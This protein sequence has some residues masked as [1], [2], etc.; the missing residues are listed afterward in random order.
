MLR[1]IAGY[2]VL[3]RS[4]HFVSLF[5]EKGEC[6]KACVLHVGACVCRCKSECLLLCVMH[7]AQHR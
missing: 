3:C 4:C 6:N 1:F 7:A 2:L 5:C